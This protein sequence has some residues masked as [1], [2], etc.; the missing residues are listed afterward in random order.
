MS[1][2]T[3]FANKVDEDWLRATSVVLTRRSAHDDRTPDRYVLV[4]HHGKRLRCDIFLTD[5][6][7]FGFEDVRIWHQL[8]LVG[9]GSTVYC[10]DLGT[11]TTH[12]YPLDNYFNF[13][14]TGDEYC[15]VISGSRIMRLNRNGELLWRSVEIAVDGITISK[16]EDD[17]IAGDAEHDPPGRWRPFTLSLATGK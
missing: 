11:L 3:I 4:E 8:L 1:T 17:T 2:E 9:W 14:I 16:I 15:L 12:I 7:C 13:F 6:E 10:V 5:A